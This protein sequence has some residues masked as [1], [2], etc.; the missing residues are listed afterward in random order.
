M[1]VKLGAAVAKALAD[2]G[3]DTMFGV[4]GEGNLLIIDHFVHELGL[5]YVTAANE[6]GAVT[7]ANGYAQAGGRV[8]VATVTQG[9]GLTNTITALRDC[10]SAGS[11][12]VLIAGATHDRENKQF[13]EQAEYVAPTG[14]VFINVE[15]RHSVL[16]DVA[17]AVTVA[18]TERCPVVL[19]IAVE[20]QDEEVAY[21]S[22]EQGTAT[23]TP[24]DDDELEAALGMISVARRPLVL[25]GYGTVLGGAEEAVRALAERLGAPL[26]T[27]LRGKELFSGDPRSIG[28]CGGLS[29]PEGS[30]VIDRADC[31]IAIGASLS[32]LTTER[33]ALFQGKTVIECD[34]DP[35]RLGFNLDVDA[36]I[37]G[38]AAAVA[39]QIVEYLDLAE[40]GATRFHEEALQLRA[41]NGSAGYVDR[42][43]DGMVDIRTALAAVEKAVPAERTLVVDVRRFMEETVRR[44]HAPDAAA[45][46]YGASFGAVGIGMGAAIGASF[47]RSDRPALLICGD[48]GFMM[49]GLTEFNTAVRHDRDLI[50]VVLN[51]G[52]YGAEEI[53]LRDQGRNRDLAMFDWPGFEGIATALG[54]SAVTVTSLDELDGIAGVIAERRG[55]LLIDIRISPDGIA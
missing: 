34:V 53:Q 43:G 29:S 40:I 26:A 55:P 51:D 39:R 21:R 13:I 52:C 12:V 45:Y 20:I 24:L 4:M 36:V 35:A 49:T 14:A 5:T 17:R 41:A 23:P 7:M 2:H 16:H 28:I 9:P 25:A 1:S 30:A 15:S 6:F 42:S 27:T 11:P 38:D 48:G 8:G 44:V 54:G 32:K 31:I 47:A 22:V 18:R 3:V 46:V 37:A 50:C 19:N 33:G 10:V